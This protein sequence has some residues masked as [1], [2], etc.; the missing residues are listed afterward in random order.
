MNFV[1]Y[2]K[3]ALLIFVAMNLA[4]LSC[5]KDLLDDTDNDE[6]ILNIHDIKTNNSFD[7]STTREVTIQLGAFTNNGLPLEKVRME[8]YS[9]NPGEGSRNENLSTIIVQGFTDVNGV[10]STTVNLASSLSK[11]WVKP[12]Y[13]GLEEVA[14][15]SITS[16]KA[17]F[18]FGGKSSKVFN[19]NPYYLSPKS[20]S[21]GNKTVGYYTLGTWNS[22]G[23]PNY[24]VQPDVIPADLLADINASV[25]EYSK[26]PDTH[27]QY[28]ADGNDANLILIDSCDVWVTFVHE[29]AG[30]KN[31]LGYYTYEYGA[32]VDDVSD[33][34][35]Q[36]LIFPNVSYYNSGGGLYSGD[37]VYIGR[38]GPNTVIGWFIIS[39]G[40]V[41]SNQTVGSG[42]WKF[43]SDPALNEETTESLKQHVVMLKDEARNLFVLGFEDILRSSTGCDQ[44]FN[45]AVF[46]ATAN[47]IEA[48]KTTNVPPLD[49]PTDNDDDGVSNVFDDYP[50]DPDMAINN[51]Y[52][53]EGK[54]GTL[55][56]EDLWPAR[57]DYDFNDLVMDYQFNQITNSD[58]QIVEIRPKFVVRAIGAGYHNGFGFQMD[59]AASKVQSVTGMDLRYNYISIGSN[60]TETGNSKATIIPFDNAFNVLPSPGGTYVNTVLGNAFAAPDTLEIFIKF[61]NPEDL[62]EIGTPPYNPFL[63]VNKVRGS[64]V[65]LPGY[66]PTSLVNS[67]LFG[68]E[69]D[70]T[71]LSSGN[72]YKSKTNLPWAMNLPSS[73]VYPIEKSAITA[74][75]LKFG[76]WAQSSGFS[77]MDWYEDKLGYRN[78]SKLYI[79]AGN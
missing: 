45:D 9:T 65:H 57:G 78:T 1:N 38:F 52:P 35:N 50:E 19:R 7:W 47:P 70:N 14:E 21:A 30:Y 23:V 59:I 33:I 62:D 25:P 46:Y 43:Y 72:Y 49:T 60:G 53:A 32:T 55:A 15:V 75:H 42:N 34:E 54:F 10:F 40:Y 20:K 24:L 68:T 18:N 26:L 39:N 64:E 37:K 74:G 69:D 6:P 27:P 5:Q 73:F 2:P 44:D 31:V 3:I 76:Q 56:Y 36:T 67:S 58:N 61:T 66:P 29:G 11:I 48:V 8:V 4:F 17:T 77:Y 63:I 41:S 12:R 51:Y 79:R 71:N 16:N 22:S 13:I 28:L